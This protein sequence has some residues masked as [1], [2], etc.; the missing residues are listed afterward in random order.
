ML[1]PILWADVVNDPRM[2]GGVHDFE[3]RDGRRYRGPIKT[4]SITPHYD[5]VVELEW[6]AVLEEGAREWSFVPPGVP[7]RY[8]HSV[9]Y[10]RVF[11]SEGM[12]RYFLSQYARGLIYPAQKLA[13][14]PVMVRPRIAEA[15]RTN[16]QLGPENVAGGGVRRM[17]DYRQLLPR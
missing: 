8:Q 16:G 1:T 4:M 2:V 10:A 7:L 9:T 13:F 11:K 3:A 12:V 15:V 14:S 17:G 6:M 5:V